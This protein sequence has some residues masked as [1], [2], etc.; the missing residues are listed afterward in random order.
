MGFYPPD[1]NRGWDPGLSST[2]PSNPD[3]H[4]TSGADCSHCPED[5]EDIVAAQWQGP[6]IKNWPQLTPW[7]G[8]YDYN[9]WAEDVDK[10]WVY[11]R[12]RSLYRYS[13]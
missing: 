12:G 1:V 7:G 2:T 13:R 8:K 5:W 4:G 3:N 9:Y 11:S 6:Y 10:V